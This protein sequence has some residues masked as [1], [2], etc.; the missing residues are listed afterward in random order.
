M[1]EAGILGEDER[2]EL[3]EARSFVGAHRPPTHRLRDHAN[4]LFFTRLGARAVI[5]RRTR[6]HPASVEPQPDLALLR[7]RAVPTAASV[8]SDDVLLAVEVA[9][10][11]VRS[12]GS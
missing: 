7:P 5:S 1:A 6:L 3:I 11:T 9:D 4:R 8:A 10:T 12:T 2:V